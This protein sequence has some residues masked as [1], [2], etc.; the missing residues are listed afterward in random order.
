ML[1]S[2]RKSKSDSPPASPPQ[3]S[4]PPVLPL[5]P[6]S[7][8]IGT[9]PGD[10][11][12]SSPRVLRR[13]S[14]SRA[15]KHK[16]TNPATSYH[17]PFGPA[18]VPQQPEPQLPPAS[19]PKPSTTAAFSRSPS[20]PDAQVANFQHYSLPSS[21]QQRSPTKVAHPDVQQLAQPHPL[22]P[23]DQAG[24]TPL[25]R[26]NSTYSIASL[27]PS[28]ALSPPTPAVPFSI[29]KSAS[30]PNVRRS[31]KLPPTF[32]II[33]VGA[34]NT[35]KTSWIRT[36]LGNVNLVPSGVA[37]VSGAASGDDK[38]ETN[39]ST[40]EKFGM[41]GDKIGRTVKSQSITV[42]VLSAASVTKSQ[43][44]GAR[45][46]RARAGSVSASSINGVAAG[47]KFSLT[48][49]DTVGLDVPLGPEVRVGDEL[50]V[51]RQLGATLRMIEARFDE[52]LRAENQ[53][54]RHSHRSHD[55]HFHLCVYFI[56]PAS[57][58][59]RPVSTP[60]MRG[61][62]T[63]NGSTGSNGS[64][65]KS[66]VTNVDDGE[67]RMSEIDIRCLKRLGKRINILPVI[68]RSD[69]LTVQ[70]VTQ[71]KQTIKRDLAKAG[72][73]FGVFSSS[74]AASEASSMRGRTNGA[75]PSLVKSPTDNSLAGESDIAPDETKESVVREGEGEHNGEEDE[76]EEEEDDPPVR[77]IRLRSQSRSR[78]AG[79]KVA[80]SRSNGGENG[81]HKTN[82]NGNGFDVENALGDEES[83][84]E[85]VV[86][87]SEKM[88]QDFE[89]ILPFALVAPETF[90]GKDGFVR[91]FRYGTL[92]VLNPAHC[93]FPA[94][95]GA[96]TGPCMTLLKDS[97]RLNHY[98]PFRTT[99]LLARRGTQV[100]L[101]EEDREG[102][103]SDL[104]AI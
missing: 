7:P 23:Q 54:F 58:C 4:T 52:T 76:E 91:V 90:G 8:P 14:S 47:D 55:A 30:L 92:S 103:L 89:K 31:Q 53:V 40:V 79:R 81:R 10:E 34:K 26:A 35:G 98:E 18:G 19:P 57:V 75:G 78:L 44:R 1:F 85:S 17:K 9:G 29:P 77:L 45:L 69:E 61:K 65:S 99:R 80:R 73:N 13:S 27:Y 42:D 56:H 5:L 64:A 97:T 15:G 12:P 102:I 88:E 20:L 41:V 63:S 36:V 83:E 82:G 49:V 37:V 60:A 101:K 72:L 33:V 46:G 11:Q 67:P 104:R 68:A 43:S 70:Q 6:P 25:A 66:K 100:I 59:A 32:N 48:C 86:A 3:P 74:D 95:L 50:E 93:D 16:T 24:S 39:T 94:L 22:P 96:I 84:D 2:R 21:Q 38:T 62:K 51:E 71:L 28:P 87:E